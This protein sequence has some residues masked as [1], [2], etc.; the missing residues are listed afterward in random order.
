VDKRILII[1]DEEE[2]CKLLEDFLTRE[3][4]QVTTAL[5]AKEGLEKL[6]QE[7]IEVILLDIK[8]PEMDGI[9]AIKRIR[10]LNKTV[11]IIM[12]TAVM[13]QKVA[14]EA[15]KLGASEYIVKPFD[16]NYLKNSL[17]VKI[18]TLE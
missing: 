4:F 13:D 16:L 2:V 11:G 8:M 1:D 3:G 17:L 5:S 14:E 15:I 7:K 9:E 18:A 10:E 12:T 6:Q